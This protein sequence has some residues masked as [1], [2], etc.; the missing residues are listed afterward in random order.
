MK[1]PSPVLYHYYSQCLI[2]CEFM[3]KTMVHVQGFNSWGLN[4]FS[5]NRAIFKGGH[6][7][8][9]DLVMIESSTSVL[10][11]PFLIYFRH[12]KCW[13]FF[14]YHQVVCF[15]WIA[16]ILGK[17]RVLVDSWNHAKERSMLTKTYLVEHYY[18]SGV[19]SI[20]YDEWSTS[21]SC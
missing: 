13:P 7:W 18:I 21:L 5:N 17:H 16:P 14:R 15:I 11:F 3:S 6:G 2:A 1:S 19:W 8:F 4:T 9:V 12:S 20:W 10:I